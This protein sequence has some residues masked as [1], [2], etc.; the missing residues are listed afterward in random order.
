[1][2]TTGRAV[3]AALALGLA[4]G[5]LA[6][7]PRLEPVR[8]RRIELGASK[9][10]LSASTSLRVDRLAAR[11]AI[12]LLRTPPEGT[13]AAVSGP[14]VVVL[15]I[16]TSMPFGR[17][18]VTR[19]LLD[20]ST[21]SVLQG[22]KVVSGGKP[23]EKVFRYTSEGYYF[24]RAAPAS[25]DEVMVGPDGWSKR[26]ARLVRSVAPLPE[27]AAV[28]DSY[29]L[30]YLVSAAGLNRRGSVFTTFILVD[31]QPVELRFEAG[32]LVQ[33]DADYQERG[34]D[35]VH[36]RRGQTLL[37]LVTVRARAL[38]GQRTTGDVDLGFFGMRSGL[39]ILVDARTGLPVQ[40][41]GRTD[42][43]GDLTVNLQAV[44]WASLPATSSPRR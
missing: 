26:R 2:V 7:E 4:G 22:S 29:A 14:E 11:A 12:P 38:D 21:G 23:Y 18:E 8:W 25:T 13:P 39:R 37:R 27:G 42:S 31:D 16:E 6:A 44:E 24:W 28:T 35:G 3:A 10:L 19:V 32:G 36:R 41:A 33:Q 15:T 40:V 5:A 9:M 17:H 1:M 43:V 30:I 34:V 20:P